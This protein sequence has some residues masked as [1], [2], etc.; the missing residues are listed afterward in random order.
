MEPSTLHELTL[1]KHPGA[2][3]ARRDPKPQGLLRV[4]ELSIDD[5]P[6]QSLNRSS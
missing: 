1:L 4:R 3:T 5:T 2:G 6:P